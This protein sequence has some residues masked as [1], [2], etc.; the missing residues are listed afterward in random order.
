MDWIKQFDLFL[1]DFDGLLVNTEE[2]HFGAYKKMCRD[3]G[4]ELPWS[5]EKYCTKAHFSSSGIREGIEEDLPDL[6]AQERDWNVLYGEKK[7]AYLELLEKGAVTLMPGVEE[8]LFHLASSEIKRCVV[9]HSSKE[10]VEPIRSQ[11][12]ILETISLWIMREDYM[13]PKP[14]PEGYLKA[15]EKLKSPND[16]IIG[17]EDTYKGLQALQRVPC[18]PVIISAFFKPEGAISHFK[19]F[20][21]IPSNLLLAALSAAADVAG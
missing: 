7:R 17:F 15:L 12:P 19:S 11:L 8:L 2:L 9:T 1:F 5:F 3:R 10:L 21:K 4:F 13:H 6:I 16:R 14:H 20:E 18:H